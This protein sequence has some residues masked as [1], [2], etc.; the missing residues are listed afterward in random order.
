M[1][2]IYPKLIKEV[3][4]GVPDY[5]DDAILHTNG[6]LYFLKGVRYWRFNDTKLH[7]RFHSYMYNLRVNKFSF[8]SALSNVFECL[9]L[10]TDPEY[11]IL[12]APEWFSCHPEP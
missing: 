2:R 8:L 10:Q 4:R 11:P 9:C 5:I 7:V 1:K 6:L 12:S 3:W